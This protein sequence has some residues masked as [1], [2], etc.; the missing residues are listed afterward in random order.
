VDVSRLF[1]LALIVLGIA[2]GHASG[3]TVK[4]NVVDENNAPV[5]G[6]RVRFLPQGTP[7]VVI[8]DADGAF[9]VVWSEY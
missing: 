7:E 2:P 9:E 6:A 1:A 4:G 3:V 8:S 5:A